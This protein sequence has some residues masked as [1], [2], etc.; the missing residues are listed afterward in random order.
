MDIK[1]LIRIKV[2]IFFNIS[3]LLYSDIGMHYLIKEIN[4]NILSFQNGKRKTCEYKIDKFNNLTYKDS[5]K[6]IRKKVHIDENIYYYNY[7]FNEVLSYEVYSYWLN[8]EVE[9]KEEGLYVNG[10]LFLL[11]NE[12]E[13][14][15]LIDY[16]NEKIK[17][18]VPLVFKNDYIMGEEGSGENL[19]Y[20]LEKKN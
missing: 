18:K 17:I 16:S 4:I 9:L 14:V 8:K 12:E 19:K 5:E 1:K 10:D 15:Y 20:Y 13:E 11:Y 6:N 2:I 7:L 3:L